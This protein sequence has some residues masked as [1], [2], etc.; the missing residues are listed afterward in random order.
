MDKAE[1]IV[2]DNYEQTSFEYLDF[3][4]KKSLYYKKF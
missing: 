1:V 4:K 2:K 3:K